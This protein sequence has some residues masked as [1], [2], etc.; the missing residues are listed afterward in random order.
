MTIL[1]VLYWLLIAAIWAFNLFVISLLL[2]EVRD[3]LK[4]QPKFNLDLEADTKRWSA[5]WDVTY[6]DHKPQAPSESRIQHPSTHSD[7]SSLW[8]IDSFPR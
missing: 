8:S 5:I 6:S 2:F 4:P 3:A 7:R 1:T